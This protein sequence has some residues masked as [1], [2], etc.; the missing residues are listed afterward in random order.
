VFSEGKVEGAPVV[1]SGRIEELRRFEAGERALVRAWGE[2]VRCVAGGTR[3]QSIV[4]RHRRHAEL[5]AERIAA[6]GGNPRIDPDDQWIVGPVTALS[7]LVWAEARAQRAFHD[8]LI[9]LDPGS[10]ALVRDVVLPEHEDIVE[11]LTGERR[12]MLE[13]MER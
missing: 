4:E 13:G 10:M 5:L 12:P 8:H 1:V 9:D 3:F 6:L 2:H 7:T 11:A